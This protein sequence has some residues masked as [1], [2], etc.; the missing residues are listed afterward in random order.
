MTLIGLPLVFSQTAESELRVD[1]TIIKSGKFMA[2]EHLVIDLQNGVEWMRCSADQVWNGS[3][4][5]GEALKLSQ[6]DVSKAIIIANDQ[7]GPGLATT[8]SG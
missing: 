5:E 4:C 1:K 8:N 7:L 6:E 3:G 2:R